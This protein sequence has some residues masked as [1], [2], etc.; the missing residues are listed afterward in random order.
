MRI[1]RG[2]SAT[3]VGSA[4]PETI[5]EAAQSNDINAATPLQWN[6]RITPLHYQ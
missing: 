2:F 5:I 1:A 6:P 4:Q 3:T